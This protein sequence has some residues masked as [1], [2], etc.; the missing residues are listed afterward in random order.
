MAL[1]VLGNPLQGVKLRLLERKELRRT[2]NVKVMQGT[3]TPERWCGRSYLSEDAFKEYDCRVSF[4]SHDPL[5][6]ILATHIKG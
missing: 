4:S 2:R 3:A 6:R 1:L 5:K